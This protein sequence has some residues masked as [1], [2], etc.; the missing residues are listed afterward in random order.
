MNERVSGQV[1][2]STEHVVTIRALIRF[3]NFIVGLHVT[4]II[5]SAM[6]IDG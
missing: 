2:L 5:E 4:G 1:R 6:K 3:I